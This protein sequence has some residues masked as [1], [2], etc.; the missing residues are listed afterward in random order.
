MDPPPFIAVKKEPLEAFRSL[1]RMHS[2]VIDLGSPSPS[3]KTCPS[4]AQASQDDAHD[5]FPNIGEAAEED[6]DLAPVVP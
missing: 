2:A 4:R 6:C 5:G 1:K 3:K